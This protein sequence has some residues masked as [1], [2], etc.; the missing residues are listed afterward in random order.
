VTLLTGP[1]HESPPTDGLGRAVIYVKQTELSMEL[2][3]IDT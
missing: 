3:L 2:R 1:T